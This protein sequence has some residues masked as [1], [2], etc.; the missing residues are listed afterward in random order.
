VK[1]PTKKKPAVLTKALQRKVASAVKLNQKKLEKEFEKKVQTRVR[2]YV[3]KHMPDLKKNQEELNKKI[4]SYDK[5]I[6]KHKPP[7]TTDE[8]KSVLM[9]L[10]PDGERTKERLHKVFIMFKGREAQLTKK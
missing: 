9:C 7:F 1:E 3:Q 10:H 4:E 2:E 6:N 5:M 8:F